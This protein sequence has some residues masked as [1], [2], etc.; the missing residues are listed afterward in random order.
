[1]GQA[2]C[3]GQPTLDRNFCQPVRAHR[4]YRQGLWHADMGF[5]HRV[6]DTGSNG[7]RL[8]AKRLSPVD[9][10]LSPSSVDHY[11]VISFVL[12]AHQLNRPPIDRRA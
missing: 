12:G 8:E 5:R 11:F 9:H 3:R 10:T 4:P 6:C 7:R 2:S 1:M